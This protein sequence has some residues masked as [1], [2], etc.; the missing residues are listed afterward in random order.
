MAENGPIE[1]VAKKVSDELLSR[2]KW[3]RIGPMDQ[4]FFCEQENIHKPGNKDQKHTHP[5][6]VVFYYKDPYLKKIIYLNTDLKSYKAESITKKTIE[7]ALKSLSKTISCAKRSQQWQDRYLLNSSSYDIRG[8]L[9]VYNHDNKSTKDFYEFFFPEKPKTGKRASAVNVS[10]LGLEKNSQIHIIE[11][12]IINYMMTISSD[13]DNLISNGKF[14]FENDDYGF[15]YPQ[16]TLHKTENNDINKAATI[17]LISSSYLIIKHND[18]FKYDNKGVKNITYKKGYI[19]YY[20][21]EGNEDMEFLY[22]LDAL[23]NFQIFDT[24]NKIR[25]RATHPN[26]NPSIKSV[27]TRALN[28]YADAW[29]LQYDENKSILEQFEIEI[30]SIST[31]KQFHCAEELSWDN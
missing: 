22:L 3:N 30:E 4:D 8:L 21:R 27:F 23:S 20:N 6:D 9:F 14:P 28:K 18:V 15:H 2:F 24:K 5:T 16:L 7:D 10:S 29:G 12:K 19:I 13:L 25:I 31:V 26:K 17:E 1:D 11:P